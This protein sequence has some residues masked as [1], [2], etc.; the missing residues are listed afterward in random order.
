MNQTA[1]ILLIDKNRTRYAGRAVLCYKTKDGYTPVSDASKGDWWE[2]ECDP[3][4]MLQLKRVFG[5]LNTHEFGTVHIK[6]NDETCRDLL[7]FTQRYPL[8]IDHY[9]FLSERAA[10]YDKRIREF[11]D[12]L[13]GNINP[14]VFDLA[15]PARDYQNI[16]TEL[17]LRSKGLLVADDLGLGKTLVGIAG[18]TRPETRPALIVTLT[19]LVYQWEREIHK[20][21][22]DLKTHSIKKGTPFS[23]ANTKGD[24]YARFLRIAERRTNNAITAIKALGELTDLEYD[25]N[26]A[27]S[28]IGRLNAAAAEAKTRF[29]PEHITKGTDVFIINYNKLAGWAETFAGKIKT[30]IFDECQELR[31]V[32]SKKYNAAIHVT[33]SADFRLGLSATPFYNY[34]DEMWNVINVLRREALGT[35]DEF[36]REWCRNVGN[37]SGSHSIADPKAFGTYLRSAGLMLRRKRSDVS[38]ELPAVIKIP[39]YVEAD[40]SVLDKVAD[41]ASELARIILS[42]NTAVLERGQAA[43]DLDWRLRQ[44][45]GISKAPYVAEFVKMLLETGEKVVLFG[46]HREVYAIWKERLKRYNPVFF[47]GTESPKKKEK[48]R[49]AFCG[50]DAQ[51]LIMSLRAG[52]GLDGLQYHSHITVFGELDWSPGVHEQNEGRENRD[53]QTD[54]VLAYYL[55]AD[56]GSDPAIADVLGIKRSQIEGVRDPD[57]ELIEKLETDVNRV[58]KLAKAYLEQQGRNENNI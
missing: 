36:I 20:F 24:K 17:W 41:S 34:G 19:H 57:A 55:L 43:R 9:D 29:S 33:E 26:D 53:G 15:I 56:H 7:W 21:A 38:R 45:T 1:K 16:A 11:D 27:K 12:L 3:H 30:V 46:W 47:T 5:R 8:K 31:R 50:G 22:P 35:R 25:A 18:L 23:S 42:K 40:A 52:A 37:W 28:I 44:A 14:R 51:V 58:T 48:S 2:I 10:T 54:T 13:I 6:A 4:V 32:E 39:H 49:E